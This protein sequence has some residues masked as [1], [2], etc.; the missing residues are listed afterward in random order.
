[1]P[2]GGQVSAAARSSDQSLVC[3]FA[4]KRLMIDLQRW[5]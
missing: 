2:K 4:K 1:M 5:M 3:A